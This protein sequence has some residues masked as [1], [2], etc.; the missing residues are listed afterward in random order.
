MRAGGGEKP[1]SFL[2]RRAITPRNARGLPCGGALSGSSAAARR[3]G[4]R[5]PARV[6]IARTEATTA[7]TAGFPASTPK[8]GSP[9]PGSRPRR[10]RDRWRCRPPPPG[11]PVRGRALRPVRREAPSAAPRRVAPCRPEAFPGERSRRPETARERFVH[12]RDRARGGRLVPGCSAVNSSGGSP[13]Q[14]SASCGSPSSS[15][16]Q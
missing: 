13:G 1:A 2:Q 15:A 6:A 16:L 4:T 11:R 3:A 14:V 10:G 7:K 9:S 8:R 12:D 5:L